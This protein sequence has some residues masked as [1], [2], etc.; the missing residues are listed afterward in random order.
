MLSIADI[1][2]KS[3]YTHYVGNGAAGDHLEISNSGVDLSNPDLCSLLLQF[4]LTPMK[5]TATYRFYHPSGDV[6]MNEVYIFVKAI[7][8]T[9]DHIRH[10]SANLARHLYDVTTLPNIKSGELHVAYFT[11][12]PVNGQLVDAVGIYKTESKNRYLKV[13]GGKQGYTFTPDEGFDPYKIDKGCIILNTGDEG[14]VIHSL[15]RTTKSYSAQFWRD[16]FL[17]IEPAADNYHATQD[18]MKLCKEFVEHGMPDEFEVECTQQIEILNK[19]TAYF[20]QNDEFEKESF[21]QQVFSDPEVIKSFD[22][23]KDQYQSEREV[24]L[25]STFDI[26]SDAVKKNATAMKKVLKLDKNFH[27]YIHGS[28]DRIERGYD[29]VTGLSFYKIYFEE[30]A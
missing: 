22:R 23:Y 4:Y 12:L 21:E 8:T 13:Q 25:Q 11:G 26:S 9:P 15:D 27:V 1:Q 18:Y 29:Q 17:R 5:E 7:F 10:Q 30:E 16:V 24:E 20:K 28:G 6:I 2:L 19:A 14:Y 3:L